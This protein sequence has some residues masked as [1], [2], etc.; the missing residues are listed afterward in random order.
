MQVMTD[1]HAD[2]YQ[3]FGGSYAAFDPVT[4]LRVGVKVLQECIAR[5]GSLLGG[6]R[7]TWALPTW[8]ATAAMPTR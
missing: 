5:A 8:P 1:V 2:K 6:L 7:T 3:H 4:N